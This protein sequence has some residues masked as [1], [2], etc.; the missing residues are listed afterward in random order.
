VRNI[1]ELEIWSQPGQ[2][3]PPEFAKE[4]LQIEAWNA[5]VPRDVFLGISEIP[6]PIDSENLKRAISQGKISESDFIG[7]CKKGGFTASA[8][9]NESAAKYLEYL[10]GR[11]LA[12][13]HLPEDQSQNF[14]LA[15]I[16][17]LTAQWGYRIVDPEC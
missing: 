3:L 6:D 12:W 2:L 7:F 4:T 13:L 11:C 17:A 15:K 10:N 14:L 8:D 9:S 1:R 5:G 16:E